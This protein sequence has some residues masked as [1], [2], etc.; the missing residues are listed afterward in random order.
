MRKTTTIVSVLALVILT[1]VSLFFIENLATLIGF[2]LD[3]T[4]I[5]IAGLSTFFFLTA[6]VSVFMRRQ[7]QHV[8]KVEKSSNFSLE[9]ETVVNSIGDG[10]IVIDTKGVIQLINPAAVNMVGW[11][12]ED[13]KNLH[14]TSVLRLADKN[15]H[16]LTEEENPILEAIKESKNLESKEYSIVTKFSD[17]KIPVHLS[18]R[19][20]NND[21]NSI[22]ITFRDIKKE[23]EDEAEQSEFIGV[24]SHEMRTPVAS[25][26]GYLG[27]A[28]NP[29]TATIDQRAKEYLE[30][31]HEAS[32]HLGRLFQDLLDVTKSDDKRLKAHIVPLEAIEFVRKVSTS[33]LPQM[34]AK[35]LDFVYKPDKSSTG[36]KVIAPVFYIKAD[37][38][39]LRE[40]LDGIIENAIKYTMEGKIE[41]DATADDN[42]I[43]ISVSDTGIGIAPEDVNHIFQKFYRVDNSDTREIGGTGLGLYITKSKVEDMGGRIWVDSKL[44]K[45]STFFIS[46]P[47]ITSEEYNDLKIAAEQEQKELEKKENSEPN[48]F[49]HPTIKPESL[50]SNYYPATSAPTQPQSPPQVPTPVA[51]PPATEQASTVKTSNDL[52]QATI[53]QIRKDFANKI[54]GSKT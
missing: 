47:R 18:V 49:L 17:K 51:T 48:P 2:S 1:I 50:N 20:A 11:G 14:F 34:Q 46:L 40:A 28:L 7:E 19:V 36:S 5:I 10:V 15:N 9:S 38:D 52:D 30:K 22:V 33:Q 23:L 35:G 6:F 39:F 16:Q 12:D 53:D 37:Q 27:L 25:I 3:H 31:A 13:T 29:S 43:V 26:E 21:K 24:A 4:R 54:A 45:G 8:Q 32:K 42:N 41:V 44:G